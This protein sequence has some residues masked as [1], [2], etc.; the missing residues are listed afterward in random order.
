MGCAKKNRENYM[1]RIM[2]LKEH[3]KNR[4][5]KLKGCKKIDNSWCV[6]FKVEQGKWVTITVL[7]TA[8]MASTN[9]KLP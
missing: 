7:W 6:E 3:V 9:H 4:L 5:T 8:M 2:L 1:S